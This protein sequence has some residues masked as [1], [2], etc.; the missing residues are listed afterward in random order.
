VPHP[1]DIRSLFVVLTA[2]CNLTCGY[3]YQNDKSARRMDW[4]T[5]RASLDWILG[6]RGEE[7]ELVFF[8]GEP[9]LEMPFIRRAVDYLEPQIPR[10]RRV[11]Y[12]LVTNGT[13]MRG[14]TLDYLVAHHVDTQLSFDGVPAA[15]D[16]RGAGTFGVLDRLLDGLRERSPGFFSDEL[17]IA[18]TV[19]PVTVG[20]LADSVAY[21]LDKGVQRIGVSPVFTGSASWRVEQIHD[22]ETQFDRILE[23]SLDRYWATGEIPFGGFEADDAP[24]MHRPDALGMCGVARGEQPV[25][26]VDGQVHGCVTFAD[27]FQRFP[28]AFLKDRLASIRL[29]DLRDPVLPERFA[30][31]EESVHAAGIF[32]DKQLKRSSY[33]ACGDCEYLTECMVCPVSIGHIPGN[34]DPHR[35]PDFPCAFNLVML[36][37]RDRFQ[38]AIDPRNLLRDGEQEPDDLRA[39]AELTR[40]AGG[41]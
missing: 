5:L 38:A 25:V 36:G 6:A 11:K 24:N 40:G 27:S 32:H 7:V 10:G 23:S 17:S 12:G 34:Q 21:F 41:P 26:D 4:E 20:H 39:L 14:D 13:L 35:V 18:I 31:F 2:R 1:R 3:C 9:L 33:R 8:G 16:V 37:A 30:R 19:Q 28:S 22:L 29:G 15:Q